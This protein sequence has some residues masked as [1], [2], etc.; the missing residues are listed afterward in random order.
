MGPGLCK[1]CPSLAPGSPK[2]GLYLG[3]APYFGLVTL[4]AC[5]LFILLIL[6][7]IIILSL[8]SIIFLHTTH[9]YT[10]NIS[11]LSLGFIY[12]YYHM[13]D[14][15]LGRVGRGV[16]PNVTGENIYPK[17]MGN[18]RVQSKK[19]RRLTFIKNISVKH[20]SKLLSDFL[21]TS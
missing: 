21:S 6:M 16:Q 14:L 11:F 8:P 19:L 9:R 7:K 13:Q 2:Y 4:L 17:Y 12:H 3:P 5:R 1:K 10:S 20:V 18:I 15:G